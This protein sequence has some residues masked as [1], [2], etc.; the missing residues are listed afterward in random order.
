VLNIINKNVGPLM[1][2]LVKDLGLISSGDK[3]EVL[4]IINNL[5]KNNPGMTMQELLDKYEKD[6]MVLS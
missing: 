6:R 4:A 2:E 3:K 1:K 5:A